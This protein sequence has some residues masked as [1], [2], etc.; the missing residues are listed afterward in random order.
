M[1]RK[2]TETGRDKPTG[3]PSLLIEAVDLP[4]RHKKHEE[5]LLWPDSSD[6]AFGA[7]ANEQAR[8]AR[9]N[10]VQADIELYLTADTAVGTTLLKKLK[11]S[12]DVKSRIAQLVQFVAPTVRAGRLHRPGEFAQQYF[13]APDGGRH[14][15]FVAASWGLIEF[16]AAAESI[17]ADRVL[18]NVSG[19]LRHAL[20]RMDEQERKKTIA[21]LMAYIG[22][23]QTAG[24]L[25][26][27]P[28]DRLARVAK[29]IG[30][31]A[32]IV[33][34][35][36]AKYQPLFRDRPVDEAT[37]K[38]PTAVEWFDQVWKPRVEAGE[39]T[40]DDIR[41]VD[42]AFYNNFAA[43]LSKRGE[44]VRDYLPPSPT[45][46]KKDETAEQRA[47]RLRRH[48]RESK[49]RARQQIA[50]QSIDD[51]SRHQQEAPPLWEKEQASAFEWF[52]LNWRPRIETEGLF[53][54]D[55]KR[56]DPQLYSALA[57]AQTRAGA[58]LGD[59]IP[60]RRRR[61]A[62]MSAEE[63]A[64]RDARIRGQHKMKMRRRRAEPKPS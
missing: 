31:A 58:S 21:G 23:L 55:L 13:A 39:A 8:A 14:D 57:A 5:V 48:S 62:T 20:E 1:A 38:K 46:G 4:L 43:A 12:E 51:E 63:L 44:K 3:N 49:R 19:I 11:L 35:A 47:E 29:L 45:R 53:S 61:L 30:E 10:A 26:A 17:N 34:A 25:E 7:R 60:L 28:S 36:P 41:G 6:A 37:G 54:D 42:P 59:L 15:V 50:D 9:A 40:G 18:P 56:A 2:A 64:E 22:E 24:V 27:T 52:N 33:S 16:L 32:E